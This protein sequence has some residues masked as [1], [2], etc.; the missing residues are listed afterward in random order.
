MKSQTK[1]TSVASWSH[2]LERKH[3]L[4]D[5]YQILVGKS[6][7]AVVW[8]RLREVKE[9]MSQEERKYVDEKGVYKSDYFV[10]LEQMKVI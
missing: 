4:P 8:Q 2:Q 1:D 10:K 9:K 5:C 3:K 6:N 7:P